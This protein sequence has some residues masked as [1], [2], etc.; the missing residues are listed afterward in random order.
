MSVDDNKP[1]I[2]KITGT[3]YRRD[4]CVCGKTAEREKSFSGPDMDSVA[5][6]AREWEKAPIRHKR[7]EGL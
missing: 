6:Q 5:A 3:Y 2:D 1:R 7:C 4:K